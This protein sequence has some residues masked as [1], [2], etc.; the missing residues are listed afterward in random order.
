MAAFASSII[1][2]LA[3]PSSAMIERAV[4]ADLDADRALETLVPE[5]RGDHDR[6]I[7]LHDRCD[8]RSRRRPLSRWFD[9]VDRLEVIEADGSDERPEFLF[10]GRI[11]AGGHLGGIRLMRAV[12]NC[13]APRRLFSYDPQRPPTR[14]P[15]G[16]GI[17]DFSVDM[18]DR[19]ARFRGRELCLYEGLIRAYEPL[20]PTHKRVS[21]WRFDRV[22]DRYVRYRART[23]RDTTGTCD[24]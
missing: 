22:A 18:E 21:L 16:F 3:P 6:R 9:S 4:R 19:T 8:G 20:T 11:G 15:R 5:L 23:M 1:P 14:A 17:T 24:L 7:V 10:D 2:W 13:R 12:A